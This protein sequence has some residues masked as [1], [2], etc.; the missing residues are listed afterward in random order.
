MPLGVDW[1]RNFVVKDPSYDI[2]KMTP[3]E[4]QDIMKRSWLEYNGIVGSNDPD[5]SRF[6]KSGGKIISWHGVNDE[7]LTVYSTR[8]YYRKLMK[9]D[10]NVHSYYRHFEVPGVNHCHAP[11]GA[12]YPLY[13]LQDLRRWVE[14]GVEPEVLRG[15]RLGEN[16]L[17]EKMLI[18]PYPLVAGYTANVETGICL[19]QEEQCGRKALG[20]KDEL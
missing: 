8:Q 7:L 3:Q 17:D 12:T 16:R 15:V 2:R 10:S 6:K 14:D 5:L 20:G 19:R 18:C 4:F 13:A 1:V 11:L 9:R